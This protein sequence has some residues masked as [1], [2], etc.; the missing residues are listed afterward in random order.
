MAFLESKTMTDLTLP[1]LTNLASMLTFNELKLGLK[2]LAS[3]GISGVEK[4]QTIM[5]IT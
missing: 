3:D 5:L 4:G 1:L 2:A